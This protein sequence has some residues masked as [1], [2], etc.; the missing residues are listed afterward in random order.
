M[1]RHELTHWFVH[2]IAHQCPVWLNEGLAQSEEPRSLSAFSPQVRQQLHTSKFP[3]L[4]EL[5]TPF[6]DMP[7][8]QA[9][10][11]YAVSLAAVDYLRTNYGVE[12][13]R[14]TL[15]VLGEGKSIDEALHS[16]TGIGYAELQQNLQASLQG[17]TP[18]ASGVQ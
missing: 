15:V 16:A 12:G 13:V 11:A 1:F 17:E 2:E 10:T 8:S 4:S 18:V 14:R 7:A 9:Q 6:L 5:E 3:A